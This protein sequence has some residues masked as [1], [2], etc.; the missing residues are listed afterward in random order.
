M[1]LSSLMVEINE[2]KKELIDIKG[3]KVIPFNKYQ[4]EKA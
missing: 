4:K 2:L 1:P 3:K